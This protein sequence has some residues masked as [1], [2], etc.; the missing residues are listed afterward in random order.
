MG[1]SAFILSVAVLAAAG[2]VA[3][4]DLRLRVYPN[5]FLAG[6]EAAHIGYTLPE[7]ARVT[8]KVYDATGV[9]VRT[10]RENADRAEGNHVRED[11]WDGRDEDGA[12]VAPG[13]YIIVLETQGHD[14][15]RRETFVCIVRR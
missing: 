11:A 13:P 1:R 12:L 9:F 14:E 15:T 8:L 4:E 2:I 6:V 5:P 3:A 7:A 10:L